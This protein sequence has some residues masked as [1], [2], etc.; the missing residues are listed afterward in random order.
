MS[1]RQVSESPARQAV[2]S[3]TI[4]DLKAVIAIDGAHA[5]QVRRHFYAKRM[6]AAADHPEDFVHLGVSR[7]GALCGF[8]IARM[9]R[10]EFGRRQ[11]VAVLDAIGV[12][13]QSQEHGVGRSLIQE[14]ARTLRSM[15]VGVLHSQVDWKDQHLL[16][17][18]HASGF[19]I[20][21]RLA[22]ER[23]VR[24]PLGEAEEEA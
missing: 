24:E 22:L 21:P 18:L 23:S 11:A 20:A 12:A 4:D 6:A 2:R 1:A 13:P 16:R 15:G 7:D 5:G 9:L 3:L 14:L 19:E 17:F 8:A 10:G